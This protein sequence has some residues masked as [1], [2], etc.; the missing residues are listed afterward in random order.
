MPEGVAPASGELQKIM[1]NIFGEFTDWTIVIFDNLLVLA[2]EWEDAYKKLNI[3]LD[4]CIERNVF[5]KFSKT[6]LG[7]DHANFFGYVVKKGCYEMSA[8]RKE[9]ISK[10]PFPTSMK[11]MQSF[12][13]SALFFK[14]F[15][16]RF[17]DLTAPLHDMVHKKFNW[18][19]SA[20]TKPYRKIFEDFKTALQNSVALHYPDYSLDWI[21]RTDASLLAV[22][23]I[24]FQIKPIE[25]GPDEHVTIGM[26]SKKFSGTARNWSTIEQESYGAYFGFQTFSYWLYAKPFVYEG[27]HNNLRWMEAS[28]VPKITR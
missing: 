12:L 2:Y 14:N 19:E 21:L 8:A 7:F 20:W 9:E 24:L 6:W 23:A 27:D 16:P 11:R 1:V 3:I 25:G 18:A 28:Q 4:R 26:A 10:I 5:L 15:V 13:G 17:S 22:G